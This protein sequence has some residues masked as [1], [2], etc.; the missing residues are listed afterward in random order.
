MLPRLVWFWLWEFWVRRSLMTWR[1]HMVHTSPT[2]QKSIPSQNHLML[3]K[4][5]TEFHILLSCF[6]CC[7]CFTEISEDIVAL[8]QPTEN[9]HLQYKGKFNRFKPAVN[10]EFFHNSSLFPH[11]AASF[12]IVLI[13]LCP[14]NIVHT[15]TTLWQRGTCGTFI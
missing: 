5:V 6:F 4:P 11:F 7:F 9:R 15:S 8:I 12:K 13:N 2:T 14:Q 3:L 10:S 1:V